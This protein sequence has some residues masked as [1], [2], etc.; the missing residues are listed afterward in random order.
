MNEGR[1]DV[2]AT[3]DRIAT[4][5]AATREHPWPEVETFVAD[6]DPAGAGLDLGCGNCR[7]A[8]LL[9]ERADRVLAV[10]LS[11]G[12]LEA[13]RDRAGERGFGIDPIQ[14]DASALPIASRAVNLATYVA[15]LHHLPSRAARI[16]SLD[17]LA[18]ALAPGGRALV[19]VWATTHDKF[20]NERGDEAGE[21]GFDTTVDWTLPDG[22]VVDR[23]YHIY[24]PAEFEADL[25]ESSLAVEEVWT[26]KGNCYAVVTPEQKRP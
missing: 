16:A 21:E 2:R 10:D 7:H 14:A 20:A 5:F 13:G 6:A 18:R 4:H 17:E 19:S 26:A 25:A 3:Y 9:A 12:L 11:R 23:F 24:A 1:D 22:T 15:T 8:E